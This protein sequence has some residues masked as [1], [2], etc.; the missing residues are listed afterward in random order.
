MS[1][2]IFHCQNRQRQNVEEYRLDCPD[3]EDA[4]LHAYTLILELADR[5]TTAK[6]MMDWRMA[7]SNESGSP[8]FNVP[9]S[10]VI[11][12]LEKP[13]A[14]IIE[15]G[16]KSF[17]KVAFSIHPILEEAHRLKPVASRH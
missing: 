8:L 2:F 17:T 6:A 15:I 13:D 12:S 9:F 5:F 10:S 4:V 1:R 7:V 14:V 11:S 3:L 16:K